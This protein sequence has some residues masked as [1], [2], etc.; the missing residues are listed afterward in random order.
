MTLLKTK[1]HLHRVNYKAE[2]TGSGLAT[3]GLAVIYIA[4]S[5]LY[6]H[7]ICKMSSLSLP[8]YRSLLICVLIYLGIH[9]PIL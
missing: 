7:A 9:L 3:L 5:L 2:D 6:L 8:L 4:F 1:G